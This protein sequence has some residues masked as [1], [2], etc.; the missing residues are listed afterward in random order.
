MWCGLSQAH[1][2]DND[3]D[4]E[5][6]GAPDSYI[7]VFVKNLLAILLLSLLGSSPNL[8]VPLCSAESDTK[9]EEGLRASLGDL[10]RIFRPLFMTLLFSTR[11]SSL[12]QLP[13][14]LF[15][16]LTRRSLLLILLKVLLL[17]LPRS[18]P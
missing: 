14:L 3:D 17:E 13:R 6:I 9:V 18:R 16:H 4:C 2:D 11:S 15:H 10:K 1:F 8:F 5:E 12:D 7:S